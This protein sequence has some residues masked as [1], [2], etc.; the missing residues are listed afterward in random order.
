MKISTLNRKFPPGCVMFSSHL[1][2][3]S[4]TC[5]DVAGAVPWPP[6]HPRVAHLHGTADTRSTSHTARLGL[7]TPS[8]GK[9]QSLM[10]GRHTDTR[11]STVR[12]PVRH[13]PPVL[14]P[15]CTLCPHVPCASPMLFCMYIRDKD[16]LQLSAESAL[17]G[18]TG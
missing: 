5:M 16:D 7:P 14:G 3:V 10:R 2:Q 6:Q 13:T 11:G 18:S 15:K 12:G 9:A 4:C 1:Q 17:Q 8:L